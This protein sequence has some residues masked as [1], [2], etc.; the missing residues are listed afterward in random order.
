MLGIVHVLYV[1]YSHIVIFEKLLN[2]FGKKIKLF[3]FGY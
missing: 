1:I 2:D 3:A